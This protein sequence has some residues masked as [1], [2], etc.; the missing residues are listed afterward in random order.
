MDAFGTFQIAPLLFI[1]AVVLLELERWWTRS[2]RR[3]NASPV[4]VAYFLDGLFVLSLIALALDLFLAT[5]ALVGAA[6]AWISYEVSANPWALAGVAVGSLALLG[7]IGLARFRRGDLRATAAGEQAPAVRFS[8]V[9]AAAHAGAPTALSGAEAIEG[10]THAAQ[11]T[12]EPVVAAP[13]P[14]EGRPPYSRSPRLPAP[15]EAVEEEPVVALAM[16]KQRSRHVVTP[17]PQS[18]L[19]L[20]PAEPPVSASERPRRSL[21]AP[22]AIVLLMGV[23]L[24]GGGLLFRQQIDAAVIDTAMVVPVESAAPT[25]RVDR[26]TAIPALASTAVPADSVLVTKKV[27]IDMLNVRT[28]PGTGNDIVIVLQKGAEVI[29]LSE[30]QLVQDSVWVKIRVED[31]EGWVSQKFLE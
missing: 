22:L 14:L 5:V 26:A 16:L 21:A 6:F 31:R 8:P 13:P 15:A 17:Q 4:P 3:Q 11:A 20:A 12:I 28:A 24:A 10:D 1:L 27:K 9:L 19:D 25:A 18:F 23:L 7:G 29:V 30:Q 2:R